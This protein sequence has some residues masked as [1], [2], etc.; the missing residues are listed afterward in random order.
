MMLLK[1]GSDQ[2]AKLIAECKHEFGHCQLAPIDRLTREGGQ[3]GREADNRNRIRCLFSTNEIIDFS[4]CL[5]V[6]CPQR[7]TR[8]AAAAVH[9]LI[10]G[11]LG[12]VAALVTRLRPS[13]RPS[14]RPPLP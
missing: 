5:F 13:V 7:H 6:R 12:G 1:G 3:F 14:V 11:K 4:R 8:L 2:S 10:A 9:S